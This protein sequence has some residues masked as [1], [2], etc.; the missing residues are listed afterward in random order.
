MDSD[1]TSATD[2]W[3]E[4]RRQELLAL[5]WEW[6]PLG[7]MGVALSEYDCLVDPLIAELF[8]GAVNA[9]ELKAV[10]RR[11]LQGMGDDGY[12]MARVRAESADAA[13]DPIVERISS[14]WKSVPPAP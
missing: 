1:G 11:G 10:L 9:A 8:L 4:A 5:V 6:D 12:S 14:W 13:L 2:R 3:R 7:I